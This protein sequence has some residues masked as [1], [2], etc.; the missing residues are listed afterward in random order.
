MEIAGK[1]VLVVGLGKTG[2]A[3]VR[4]L[5]RRG[6]RVAV[7]EKKT[8][9][10]LGRRVKT[11]KNEGVR[12]ETGGHRLR[13]FLQADFIIPS[14]GAAS[15]PELAAAKKRGVRVLSEV[16]LAFRFLRGRV[17]GITGTNGKS[18]TAT[19]AHKI[20]MESGQKAFL[21]GNIGT[22]L[23]AFA[24]KSRDDHIYV[25]EISSFQLEHVEHFRVFISVFLN[26]SQNHLDWHGT[27]EDYFA[28]KKKLVLAQ[29]GDGI[30][31]LN[32]DDRLV[33]SLARKAQANVYSFSTRRKVAR[34]CFLE[35]GSI[36]LQ[37]GEKTQIMRAA[38]VPLPGL[39]NQENVMAAVL[40]GHCL[41]APVVKMRR[42]IR[43][44]AGLEHR[45]ENVATLRRVG[46]V[47][48][49]KA[50]TVDATIKAIRSFDRK[51]VLILGGRDKGADFAPLRKPV[52]ER[53]K[54]VVLLGEAKEKIKRALRGIV[55]LEEAS[56]LGG[57]VRLAFDSARPGELVLL[58]PA[59]TSFDMF[60]NFEAR[61]RAFKREVRRL[62]RDLAQEEA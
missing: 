62:A 61:G 22:P 35:K 60:R 39:H 13:T 59:C 42:S 30:A 5:L 18:T 1:K 21:A 37:N 57:A 17:V 55:A 24:D 58:A 3:L 32:R 15:I 7:S 20:L 12:L 52:R 29:A 9:E 41:R 36:F 44:F 19:L 56:T 34:G 50:T 10:E 23:I 33:W 16:E 4:F 45:L 51:I 40:I 6:A 46:F 54:K 47:N 26:V 14:P 2:E 11:W 25:T 53:V 28:A 8:E 48:D 38:E 31:I 27:F 43:S 49:S